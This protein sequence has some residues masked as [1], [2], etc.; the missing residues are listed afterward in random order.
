MSAAV[1]KIWLFLMSIIVIILELMNDSIQSED[2]VERYLGIPALAVV[3]VRG[4]QEK[5]KSSKDKKKKA[6]KAGKG[7]EK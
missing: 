2:D 1:E 3:P 5:G 4:Y 6:D 7:K